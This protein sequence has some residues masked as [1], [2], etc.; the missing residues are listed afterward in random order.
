VSTYHNKWI[1]V[2]YMFYSSG[3][4]GKVSNES[5][6]ELLAFLALPSSETCE[7]MGLRIPNDRLGSDHLMLASR[8]FLSSNSPSTTTKL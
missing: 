3:S 6:L 8:F 7:Q 5:D 1:L 4:D 2:D